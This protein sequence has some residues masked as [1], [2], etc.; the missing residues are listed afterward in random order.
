MEG[1]GEISFRWPLY[2]LLW[3]RMPKKK[4]S[5][6]L[7]QQNNPKCSTWLQSQN[8]RII[9]VRFPVKPFNI[10]VT[11]IYSPST[12]AKEAEVE[13]FYED[14]QDLQE[15][16]PKKKRYPF[17][18]RGLECKTRKSRDTWNNRQAWQ[19]EAAQKLTEICKEDTMV[20]ANTHF[21]QHKR[22]L[23]TWES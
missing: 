13:W 20:I 16:T 8:D 10:T 6:P 18:H 5:S 19:N 23:Y 2:L 11:Q 7:S 14:L 12:I 15:L 4:W 22:R 1:N 21:Q 9:S 3:A 17:H